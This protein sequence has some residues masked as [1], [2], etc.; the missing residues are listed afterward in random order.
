[1]P[2]L[3]RGCLENTTAES[4]NG[5]V[6][7]YLGILQVQLDQ[8]V[9]IWAMTIL[10]VDSRVRHCPASYTCFEVDHTPSWQLPSAGVI[11]FCVRECSRD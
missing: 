1:M 6:P 10:E 3:A 9:I 11:E 8:T 2:A 4:R 5:L 7:T